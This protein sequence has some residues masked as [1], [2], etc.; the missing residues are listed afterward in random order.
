M[1]RERQVAQYHG[2]VSVHVRT[3]HGAV[4]AQ[5]LTEVGV[6]WVLSRSLQFSFSTMKIVGVNNKKLSE[7]HSGPE[8]GWI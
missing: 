8:L 6:Q 5:M 4:R 7:M 2:A 1:R 3:S